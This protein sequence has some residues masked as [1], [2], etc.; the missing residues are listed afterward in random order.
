LG[1]KRLA[2]ALVAGLAALA[3]VACEQQSE[4]SGDVSAGPASGDA[5]EVDMGDS[6]F[7]PPLLELDPGAEVTV[8]IH[9]SDGTN[10]DFAIERF[11]LNTGTIEPGDTA[12]AR[13]EVPD[14]P[15]EFVCTYHDGMTGRIVP[16][17]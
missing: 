14:E 17:S 4:P 7:Q 15:I 13:F 5:V 2:L 8:E 12:T 6:V 10:H 11:N 3:F 9:N 1:T 16:A